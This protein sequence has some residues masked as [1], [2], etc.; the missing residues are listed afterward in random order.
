MIHAGIAHV[1]SLFLNPRY[2]VSSQDPVHFFKRI[3]PST[4]IVASSEMGGSVF[5]WKLALSKFDGTL[6]T[7][8]F[9][10][11]T[12]IYRWSGIMISCL[13]FFQMH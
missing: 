4:R 3:E 6:R 9:S 13:I 12:L 11:G 10:P 8:V 1:R 5:S 7:I 2:R